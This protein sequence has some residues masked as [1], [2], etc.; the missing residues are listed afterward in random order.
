MPRNLNLDLSDL[1]SAEIAVV[2]FRGAIVRCNRKWNDTAKIGLLL[3]KQP[4]WNYIAECQAAISRGCEEAATILAGLSAVLK[5][6]LRFFVGT[7]ACPF[8]GLYHWYQVQISAFEF[9]KS[10]HAVL[11]HV[12][13]S[14]LQRDSLTGLANRAMFDAQLNLALSMARDSGPKPGV[15]IVDLNSLKLIN[16]MHGHR[17]GDEALIALAS[18]LRKSVDPDCVVARIGGDEF[19]VVLQGNCNALSLGRLRANFKSGMGCTIAAT[20]KPIFVSA[21]VGVAAFPEDGATVS[22]LLTSADKSMYAQKRSLSV[23]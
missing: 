2:D 13:V 22:E 23:A 12:D 9:N 20:G 11:M 17:V 8:G 18:K 4:N 3:V 7:Y 15:I 19:G 1:I 21:S 10:P 6:D 16:D 14:A 5:G